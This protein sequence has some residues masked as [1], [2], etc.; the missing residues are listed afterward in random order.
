MLEI[1][2]N[3]NF[4]ARYLEM[5]ALKLIAQLKEH[6]GDNFSREENNHWLFE[7]ITKSGRSQLVHLFYK[8]QV[9][10]EKDISRFIT[11]SPIGPIFRHFEYE[12]VLRKNYELE[13]GAICIE[14]F[15]NNSDSLT[16]YLVLR[17]SH[18]APTIDYEEAL[19]LINKTGTIADQLE[20]E[21]FAVDNN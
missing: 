7:V 18:L 21:I 15:K 17:A 2:L 12:K 1:I 9:L 6:Y 8:K 4:K 16:P 20:D 19:E 11:V 14:D 5:E 3:H 13:V 10:L